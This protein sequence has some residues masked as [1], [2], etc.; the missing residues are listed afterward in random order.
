MSMIDN[1]RSAL[2]AFQ[3]ALTTTAH[4]IANVNTEGYS[5][6]IVNLSARSTDSADPSAS[7]A[8][9]IV[10]RVSR[11]YDQS[12]TENLR[13]STTLLSREQTYVDLVDDI[14]NMLASTNTGLSAQG[15]VFFNSLQ[16][17]ANDPGSIP[18]RQVFISN[19]DALASRFQTM[20][21][22]LSEIES[23]SNARLSGVVRD[24]NDIAGQIATVNGTITASGN[25]GTAV[26]GDLLDTRDQLLKQLAEKV[27]VQTVMQPDQSASVF[28]GSGQSLV[29]GPNAQRLAMGS[30]DYTG[31]DNAITFV[32]SSSSS[33]ITRLLTGGE[34][35]GILEFQGS[36]LRP[37]QS[38]LGRY[39]TVLTT[40]INAQHQV[41]YG[42]DDDMTAPPLGRDLFTNTTPTVSN[43]K[44]NSGDGVVVSAI[45]TSYSLSDGV[46]S[47]LNSDSATD[48]VDIALMNQGGALKASDYQLERVAGVEQWQLTRLSDKS[49]VTID[50]VG[51]DDYISA[52]GFSFQL[53]SGTA[54]VGDRFLIRPYETSAE[55]IDV[56]Q[57]LVDDP[58]KIAVASNVHV[59]PI[60]RTAGTSCSAS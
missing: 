38:E 55:K 58:R 53:A 8:G 29:I 40:S 45:H 10:D 54:D 2:T 57:Q 31:Y 52:D 56:N 19:A 41:G 7:G 26:S 3:T 6:Q 14:D 37:A 30:G 13:S 46:I 44:S 47:D 5:R 22:R 16:D 51:V 32:S 60:S 42:L 34:I 4:N 50:A 12:L 27:A 48:S 43:H 18:S 28:I 17:V 36:I 39:A 25:G 11:A 1:S 23:T 15:Q 21:Y 59:G 20:D 33:D 9:V 49:V 24:I 35:G